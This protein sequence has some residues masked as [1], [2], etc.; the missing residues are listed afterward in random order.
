M[1]APQSRARTVVVYRRART[2]FILACTF[3]ASSAPAS[4]DGGGDA[5]PAEVALDIDQAARRAGEMSPLVRRAR[6]DRGAAEARRVEADLLFPSNPA[7][8]FGAGPTRTPLPGGFTTDTGAIAHVE[9]T[10]I[11]GQ[12]GA[13]RP[14]WRGID[15]AALREA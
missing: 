14:R 1:Y 2:A 4:T 7:V 15:G 5:P 12:R 8:L 10:V 11:G 13:R 6:A 3:S 9:Q